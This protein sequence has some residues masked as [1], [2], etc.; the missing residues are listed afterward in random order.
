MKRLTSILLLCL[1]AK[2]ETVQ[3]ALTDVQR[4]DT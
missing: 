3:E 4:L 1:A 2:A